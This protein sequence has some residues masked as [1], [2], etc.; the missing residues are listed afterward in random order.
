MTAPREQRVC[1][2]VIV[3]PHGVRGLVKIK[4]FTAEPEALAAYGP[5]HDEAG[6]RTFEI[7]LA[8][9]TKD[10]LLGR[11]VGVADRDA[12]EALKGTR[13]YIERAALPEP[14][15]ADTYYHAD[16]VGLRVEDGAGQCLG[17]VAAVHNF[18]AGDLIEV[19]RRDGTSDLLAFTRAVVPVVDVPG[20]RLVVRPPD[21]VAPEADEAG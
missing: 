2:G 14:E 6:T 4:S 21:A 17:W 13:L 18:G 20:G 9:R 5:L 3:A 7:A 16:L 10:L 12:A 11:V 8:G 19:E 1:L 15:E